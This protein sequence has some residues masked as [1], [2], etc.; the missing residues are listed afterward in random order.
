MRIGVAGIR[1]NRSWQLPGTLLLNPHRFWRATPLYLSILKEWKA[2]AKG[3]PVGRDPYI[4]LT[5]WQS[6]VDNPGTSWG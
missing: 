2:K 3:P 1:W 6:I 5:A 4:I